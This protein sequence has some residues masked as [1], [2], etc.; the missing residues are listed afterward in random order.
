MQML[1]VNSP[2][3]KSNEACANPLFLKFTGQDSYLAELQAN[4]ANPC[5]ETWFVKL[6]C[7]DFLH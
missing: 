5:K 4:W 6:H 3:I 2:F 7:M 1:V